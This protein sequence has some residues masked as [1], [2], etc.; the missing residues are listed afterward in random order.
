MKYYKLLE[1]EGYEPLIPN[2][3][4]RE[5]YRPQKDITIKD[6]VTQYPE[7]WEEVINHTPTM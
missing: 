2:M 4:Y 7:D 5:D 1:K 3:V 6:L